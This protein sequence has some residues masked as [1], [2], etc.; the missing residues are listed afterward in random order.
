[1]TNTGG[2]S[3]S[4]ELIQQWKPRIIFLVVGLIVGPIISSMIGLQVTT[5]TMGS[6][7]QDGV[8]AYRAGLC[9]VRARL[10]PEATPDVLK[11]YDGRRELAE[12]WAILPG[13]DK[14]DASVKRECVKILKET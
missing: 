13:E 8:V 7:V 1:M 11:D 14:V 5:S 6:A 2:A 4:Q 3:R 9:A 12:K 10:D